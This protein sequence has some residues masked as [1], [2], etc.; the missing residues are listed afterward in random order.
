MFRN[1]DDN[2][3]GR[4]TDT[5]VTTKIF[6]F[7]EVSIYDHGG[8]WWAWNRPL[9]RGILEMV[10]GPEM[11]HNTV[12]APPVSRCLLSVRASHSRLMDHGTVRISESSQLSVTSSS[13]TQKTD[14]IMP[15]PAFEFFCHIWF[16][17]T[18][19]R[20]WEGPGG[21]VT[22][23]ML[24]HPCMIGII[25]WLQSTDHFKVSSIDFIPLVPWT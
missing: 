13:I 17:W 14:L 24:L 25:I 5:T 23:Y 18:T 11:Q 8:G 3:H 7:W 16:G 6:I 10:H 9:P 19:E 21:S 15:S 2:S 4:N 22:H 20:L 1:T 12:S